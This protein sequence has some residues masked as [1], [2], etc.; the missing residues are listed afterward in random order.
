MGALKEKV[1]TLNVSHA[2]QP[3][4]DAAMKRAGLPRVGERGGQLRGRG[5]EQCRR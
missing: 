1:L 3:E 5:R 4:I 2:D